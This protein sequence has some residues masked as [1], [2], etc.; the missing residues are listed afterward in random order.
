MHPILKSQVCSLL[1]W[2]DQMRT[3]VFSPTYPTWA[4]VGGTSRPAG[5]TVYNQYLHILLHARDHYGANDDLHGSGGEEGPAQGDL[6]HRPG[7]LC[8]HLLHVHF[9]HSC[10]GV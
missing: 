8:L 7:L 3:R 9:L 6:P 4:L 5:E 1:V 10:P 2:E